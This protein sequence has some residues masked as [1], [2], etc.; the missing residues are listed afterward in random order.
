MDK[1]SEKRLLDPFNPE[2]EGSAVLETIG[3]P[4][5]DCL[6]RLTLK[7]KEVQALKPSV[8]RRETA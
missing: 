3:H 5:R 7:M 2:D 6:T 4:K 8:I 1:K